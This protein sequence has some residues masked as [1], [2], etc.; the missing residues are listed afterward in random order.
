MVHN[1]DDFHFKDFM[2][3]SQLLRALMLQQHHAA[4]QFD[5]HFSNMI[6]CE[7]VRVSTLCAHVCMCESMHV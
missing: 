1:V 3:S 5:M 7:Y 6:M 4:L 2:T